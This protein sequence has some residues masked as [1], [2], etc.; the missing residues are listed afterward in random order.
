M[1]ENITIPKSLSQMTL[2]DYVSIKKIIDDN[3]TDE[4]QLRKKIVQYYA[5]GTLNEVGQMKQ[6]DFD[7]ICN[8][9]LTCFQEKPELTTVFKHQGITYGFIPKLDD[10]TVH[11]YTA[12]DNLLD[13][14]STWHQA[15]AILYRPVTKVKTSGF[16]RKKKDYSYDIQPFDETN[17]LAND[18]AMLSTPASIMIGALLFFWSLNLD[19]LK[20]SLTYMEKEAAKENNPTKKDNLQ[21]TL[22]G[23]RLSI[24]L[25]EDNISDILR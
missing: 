17:P 15:A 12:L 10:L 9:I 23:V 24:S 14:A 13:D 3:Q 8:T 2:E 11:E 4:T 6:T 1:K 5:G 16:F 22:D 19:L 18:K 7:L 25:L 20:T 21:K